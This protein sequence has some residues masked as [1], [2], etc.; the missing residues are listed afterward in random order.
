MRG[1]YV[2]HQSPDLA[3]Q[4]AGLP[5]V[6]T[7]VLACCH[8]PSTLLMSLPGLEWLTSVPLPC[9]CSCWMRGWTLRAS[10][11]ATG[12]MRDSWRCLSGCTRYEGACHDSMCEGSAGIAQAATRTYHVLSGS[13]LP[14]SSP[15]AF[16]VPIGPHVL[17]PCCM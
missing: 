2:Y 5:A 3:R 8:E 14:C 6:L 15:C 12:T 1:A 10:I 11:S 16:C 7:F 9:L 17:Q 13:A 4:A